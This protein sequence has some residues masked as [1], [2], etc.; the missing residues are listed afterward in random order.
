[1]IS[2]NRDI[3][4]NTIIKCKNNFFQIGIRLIMWPFIA[5]GPNS[6]EVLKKFKMP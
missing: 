4:F 2:T 3:T 1:M 5:K 6:R